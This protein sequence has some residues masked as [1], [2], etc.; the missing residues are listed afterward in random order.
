MSTADDNLPEFF[1]VYISQHSSEQME[2]P[3]QFIDYL[4]RRKAGEARLKGPNGE[5]CVVELVNEVN[6]IYFRDGWKAFVKD[7]QLQENDF[8]F[9]KYHGNLHFSVEIYDFQTSCEKGFSAE[10]SQSH[11]FVRAEEQ[12]GGVKELSSSRLLKRS[13]VGCSQI[14]RRHGLLLTLNDEEPQVT[15]SAVKPYFVK[16]MTRQLVGP[17][18]LLWIPVSF[19]NGNSLHYQHE[20]KMV[21]RNEESSWIVKIL[22]NK[23][24]YILSGL[25]AFVRDNNI[26]KGDICT[27]ELIDRLKM[28][29]H[30]SPGDI[31]S[32]LT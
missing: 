7:Q 9:F 16:Q 29:V 15:S 13:N 6:K 32:M 28:T 23:N 10:C 3:N 18:P 2:V 11:G 17:Y 21:L 20:E 12:V 14:A 24:G 5:T 1:K 4:G 31:S 26:T 27:F 22:C 25:A 19:T 30:V 8:L